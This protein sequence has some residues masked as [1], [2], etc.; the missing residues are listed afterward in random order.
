M[1]KTKLSKKRAALLFLV[2]IIGSVVMI[3]QL[4][5]QANNGSNAP[6]EWHSDLIFP[7]DS[8]EGR[9][10]ANQRLLLEFITEQATKLILANPDISEELLISKL[11]EANPSLSEDLL[12]D[13]ISLSNKVE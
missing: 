4:S 11:K 13:A 8:D 7:S 9:D 12:R 6:F 10:I 5:I 2:I 3:A 1:V